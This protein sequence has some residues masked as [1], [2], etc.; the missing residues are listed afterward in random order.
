MLADPHL[1]AGRLR[2]V[3][4]EHLGPAAAAKTPEIMAT[5]LLTGVRLVPA[6]LPQ[7]WLPWIRDYA[8]AEVF[9]GRAAVEFD[10]YDRIYQLLVWHL[11]DEARK[12]AERDQAAHVERMRSAIEARAAQLV[13]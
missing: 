5:L 12:A 6:G 2:A 8:V 10:P 9:R 13:P 4:H 3:I 7:E 1:V 11:H